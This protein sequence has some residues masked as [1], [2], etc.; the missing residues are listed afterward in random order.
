M[1]RR[2]LKRYGLMR[3]LL[4]THTMLWIAF[5]QQKLSPRIQTILLD[6]QNDFFISV[7]SIWEINI[8][9][10]SGKLDLKDKTPADLIDGFNTYFK[11]SYLELNISDAINLYKLNATHHKDPFDRILI[12]QA[13]QNKL[14][15]ITDDEQIHKYKDCGLKVIW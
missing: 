10:S 6:S 9:F 12:W 1:D 11:C 13:I 14:T 15:I 8:K 2:R 7:V 3:Y 4:D 5:N